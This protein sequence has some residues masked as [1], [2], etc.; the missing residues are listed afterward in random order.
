MSMVPKARTH[1]RQFLY[2]L[3]LQQTGFVGARFLSETDCRQALIVTVWTSEAHRQRADLN[4][5]LQAAFQQLSDCFACQS[6]VIYCEMVGQ[7]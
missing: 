4:S 1:F 7:I 3:L 5:D 6:Q 2:P